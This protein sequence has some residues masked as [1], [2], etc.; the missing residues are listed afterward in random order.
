VAKLIGTDRARVVAEVSRLLT[1]RAAHAAMAKGVSPYG[2]GKAAGRIAA[3]VVQFVLA[4]DGRS[5]PGAPAA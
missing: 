5:V 3:L 2:D 1:D 4:R